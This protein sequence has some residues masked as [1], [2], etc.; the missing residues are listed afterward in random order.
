MEYG[1]QNVICQ[2]CKLKF[3]VEPEDFKFYEKIDVL[4]P[5]ICPTCR[6]QLRLS[7]RNERCFYKRPCDKCRKDKISM[8]SPNKPY[9]VWCYDCWF[10]DDWNALDYGLI[11]DSGKPFLDQY[12]NLLKTVPKISLIY[13]R[14][15]GSQ[16]T[17]ISADNKN[18]YMLVES[19]NNENCLN[20]Y[21][22]QV[23]K[24]LVDCSFTNKVELSYEVDDCYDCNNLKF[25]KGCHSCLDSVFLLDCRNCS[26][27]FGCVNLRGQKYNIFNVSH[28]KDEYKKFIKERKLDTESGIKKAQEEF[29]EF[30]SKNPRKYAEIIQGVNS[31][32]NYIKSSRNCKNCF[33]CYDSEDC[34]HGV[35]TW[36]DAKECF[37]VDTAGRNAE[38]IYNSI[39]SGIETSHQISSNLCWSSTFSYYSTYC[40]NCNNILGCVGLRKKDYCI[41]NKQYTKEE[42]EK[43]KIKII[44]K[45]K[46][47]EEWG[48][49]F[50][51]SISSF[52][53]NETAAYEQFPLKKE[54]AI[55]LGFKWED[56]ERGTYG[57]ETIDWKSFPDSINNLP[58]DFDV[59]KEVFICL[60]C[61]KNYRIIIDELSFY[62]KL[63]IPIPRICPECRHVKRFENRGPNKLWHRKCM[64]EGC[65]NEFK[66]S[67]AP[68][69]LEIVYCEKCYQRE[70]Y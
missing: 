36:R 50:P 28:T 40:F 45:M 53:Y 60:E 44:S 59:V 29:K 54:E 66:T 17:N 68:D 58:K 26:N 67:Y 7:F 21:W 22:I 70:V 49:F 39:N 63:E 64:K 41:L 31:T 12:N 13:V 8:Y 24:D 61:R 3:T 56:T 16:Y 47:K 20:C 11:Y 69:R 55:A 14:S 9:T 48:N 18:C 51:S 43:L 65:Q 42:Y 23:S 10:S 34:K 32:G 52:G 27:C 37:D 19:S 6:A 5:S 25:S 2:N 38:L 62:K 57:K 30:I 4:V 35:H 33:H 15:P 1:L 46:E